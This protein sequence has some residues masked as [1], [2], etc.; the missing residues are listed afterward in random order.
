MEN[1]VKTAREAAGLTQ[2]ELAKE[3]E[4]TQGY[5][6]Q[7]ERGERIPSIKTLRKISAVLGVHPASLLSEET[8][9]S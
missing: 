6:S 1:P 7:I 4:L 9:A 3:T 5:I 8:K 2:E